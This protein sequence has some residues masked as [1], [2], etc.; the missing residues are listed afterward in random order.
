MMKIKAKTFRELIQ[1]ESQS[2]LETLKE[3]GT[4]EAAMDGF[5]EEY[6][7][8]ELFF[9]FADEIYDIVNEEARQHLHKDVDS[10]AG[11]LDKTEGGIGDCVDF[12]DFC[13]LFICA[14]SD[15]LVQGR[16]SFEL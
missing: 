16:V 11:I 6:P 8:K 5:L 10:I 14:A 12:D 4:A 3:M 15:A 1:K 2:Y 13:W 7:R 9:R